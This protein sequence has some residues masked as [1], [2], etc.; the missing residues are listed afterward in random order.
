MT[1]NLIDFNT[2]TVIDYFNIQK[3]THTTIPEHINFVLEYIKELIICHFPEIQLK[4]SIKSINKLLSIDKQSI[5]H[6]GQINNII[7]Y[8]NYNFYICF[9]YMYQSYDYNIQYYFSDNSKFVISFDIFPM[10]ENSSIDPSTPST[11]WEKKFTIDNRYFNPNNVEHKIIVEY[12]TLL[13]NR[14][15]FIKCISNELTNFIKFIHPVVIIDHL[16]LK[17]NVDII[18]YF[19]KLNTS[20][21]EEKDA[22]IL[23]LKNQL[24]HMKIQCENMKLQQN[25]IIHYNNCKINISDYILNEIFEDKYNELEN[26]MKLNNLFFCNQYIG[27]C[28]GS[29]NREIT[30]SNTNPYPNIKAEYETNIKIIYDHLYN[31]FD[32][33]DNI[34]FKISNKSLIEY[35][36]CRS[37]NI[38][39]KNNKYL[40]MSNLEIYTN[41]DF[42]IIMDF[43]KEQQHLGLACSSYEDNHTKR[44][45]DITIIK[46]NTDE[47]Y[48]H[49]H[50]NCTLDKNIYNCKLNVNDNLISG[51]MTANMDQTKSYV[52]SYLKNSCYE[53]HPVMIIDF[54]SYI[55]PTM[56][57]EYFKHIDPN[58]N[59]TKDEIINNL[60][61][62]NGNNI[63]LINDQNNLI[64]Q[65]NLKL[66]IADKKCINYQNSII[67]KDLI[68]DKITFQI[69]NI[70]S[71]YKLLIEQ[72]NG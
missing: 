67:K 22:E 27:T 44:S 48:N 57:D 50:I 40:T 46:Y 32:S 13:C 6:R 53:I 65:M 11:N 60:Q 43:I 7:V 66:E 29:T 17:D 25:K 45:F 15:N 2:N 10:L 51:I 23:H 31:L 55:D 8:T 14:E 41:Y 30:T 61:K 16:C 54:L 20:L 72:T 42:Y 52:K 4:I 33:F 63:K 28:T 71:K 1:D 5:H 62:E 38:T 35:I 24:E 34:K 9:S 19:N 21:S 59:L 58:Q 56:I 70:E 12:G 3:I 26:Y 36:R 64:E 18:D 49:L 37:G 68:I 69:E 47:Q 39:Y